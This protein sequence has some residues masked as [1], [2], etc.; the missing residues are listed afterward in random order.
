MTAQQRRSGKK[1]GSGKNNY[2]TLDAIRSLV[3]GTWNIGFD[4]RDTLIETLLPH[5]VFRNRKG[6]CLG[7]SLVILML[8][9]KLSCPVYGVMLPG[10]FFCRYDDGAHRINI[11][12]NK[13]GCA[14]PDDYYR[15]RYPAENRP[16]YDLGN[17]TPAAVVGVYCYDA[18][19]LCLNRKQSAAAIDFFKESIRRIPDFA[20][21]QGNL[22]V[23]YAQ[24]KALDTAMTLFEKVYG[25]HPDLINLTANYGA[26]AMAAGRYGKA[27]EVYLKGLEFFPDDTMLHKGLE[28]AKRHL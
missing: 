19:T 7:V 10:H 8:A 5:L 9:E 21:A 18:G 28:E 12:P 26:V 11:E 1:S 22:A 3:Y 20:E 24:K 2:A 16:W 4:P 17:L 6:A 15:K 14:H 23:S 27:R 25:A 13:Q